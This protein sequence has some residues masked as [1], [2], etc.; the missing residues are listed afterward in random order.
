VVLL[1]RHEDFRQNKS[2]D[3]HI[4]RGSSSH[5]SD[6]TDKE[7]DPGVDEAGRAPAGIF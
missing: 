6:A 2:G 1:F 4:R 7:A 5:T 3:G